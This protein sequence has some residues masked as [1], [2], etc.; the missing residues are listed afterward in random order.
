M[1]F[2]G[3]LGGSSA[4]SMDFGGI[5]EE[6]KNAL[7]QSIKDFRTKITELISNFNDEAE[8]SKAFKGTALTDA[9]HSMLGDVKDLLN[10]Y[11]DLMEKDQKDLETAMENWRNADASVKNLA[12]SAAQDIRT[13]ANAIKLD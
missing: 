10:S 3:L 4:S 8:I 1:I 6:G 11:V 5:S 13:E 12:D 7:D 2:K 9:I